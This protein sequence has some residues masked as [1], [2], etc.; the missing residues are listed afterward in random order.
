MQREEGAFPNGIESSIAVS[1]SSI[2]PP[3]TSGPVESEP[4]II[5]LLAERLIT[6]QQKQK[7]AEVVI[8]KEIK[9]HI[10]EVPVRQEKLIIEQVSPS[11]K[12]I[13][14]IIPESNHFSPA[15]P[16]EISDARE[17]LFLG[18]FLNAKTAS[19]FL[20]TIADVTQ[21]ELEQ[22]EVTIR[23]KDGQLKDTYEYWLHYYS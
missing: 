1:Q 12:K 13:A 17:S 10:V 7:V 9:T 11:Y 23:L 5:Q 8:R 20:N 4:L 15:Q 21:G 22:V 2:H 3:V 16:D 19:E 18:R 6:T 14:D